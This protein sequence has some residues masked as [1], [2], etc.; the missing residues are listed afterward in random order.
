MILCGISSL[1]KLL[2]PSERQIAHAL[3]TRPPLIHASI[4]RSLFLHFTVRLAC[5]RHAASVRPEPGSNSQKNCINTYISVSTNLFKLNRSFDTDVSLFLKLLSKSG[6]LSHLLRSKKSQG[7]FLTCCLI[8]KVRSLS[9]GLPLASAC[10]YYHFAI[11]LS[12]TF[13]KFF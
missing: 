1:F 4:D 5:V 11:H 9:G 6:L 3:L 2:S 13:F 12:S 7:F 8:F 10:L